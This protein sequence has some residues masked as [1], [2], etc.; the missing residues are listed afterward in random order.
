M[1]EIL[2]KKELLMPLV[3]AL[4]LA[5]NSIVI[6]NLEG[7]I[8]WANNAFTKLSGY[9]LE[10]IVG[11]S[12]RI[13]KSGRQAP[14]YYQDLWSTISSGKVWRGELINQRKDGSHY[15][16]EMSITPIVDENG[17]ITH[18]IAIK[19]DITA[20]K[21]AEEALNE[22]LR[23]LEEQYQ[24]VEK[25]RS[26]TRAIMDATSEALLLVSTDHKFMWVNS[27]F[28][29]FFALKEEEIIGLGFTEM[30]PHF[31]RVFQHPIGLEDLFAKAYRNGGNDYRETVIQN[32]PLKRELEI[33]LTLVKNFLNESLGVLYV[34]R[35]VTHERE[36]ERLKS[37]FVSLVSHELRTPL[38]SIV[39]YV[40]MMLDG[41]AGDLGETQID[42]LQIV[43]RNS[44]R[45]KK[46]VNDLLDVS[47]IEAGAVKLNWETIDVNELIGEVVNDLRTQLESKKQVVASNLGSKKSIISGDVGR[48]TQVFTNLISNA[49]KYTPIGGTVTITSR[50]EGNRIRVDVQDT[51]IGIS[52]EDRK[53]LFTKFFRSQDSEVHNTSG[54]GLGLWISKSLVE[55]HGGNISFTSVQDKGSIFTIHLPLEQ[56]PILK[57]R[58]VN[59]AH[60]LI[61]TR[62]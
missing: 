54:T 29:H 44:D 61:T 62:G 10:E 42:F 26:E 5:S 12:M 6:T 49:N 36:V 43:K 15:Y 48:L 60:A 8:Q 47:R 2:N 1:S 53:K 51:G 30:L 3:S 22:T 13:L 58:K 18:Y 14:S 28:E 32:W 25:A 37:E 52:E 4:Q 35:D 59:L 38:T 57:P 41:D 39:G 7:T 55:M 33:Y 40:D 31:Q 46:L 56:K 45:L 11:R 19:Q 9:T 34:F 21:N 27:A 16:E 24:A 20:R 17:E 50:Q 23:R